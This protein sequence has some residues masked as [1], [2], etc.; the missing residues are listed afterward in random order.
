MG[1]KDNRITS[2]E[3]LKTEKIGLPALLSYNWVEGTQLIGNV[4]VPIQDVLWR[5][6]MLIT[7]MEN[8]LAAY[9]GPDSEYWAD[10]KIYK[11]LLSYEMSR[12]PQNHT[13]YLRAQAGW[14][15]LI[16]KEAQRLN[17]LLTPNKAGRV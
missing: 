3:E 14:I 13:K 2:F 10:A 7:D 1:Y 6:T 16:M 12:M 5:R 8:L 9:L 15:Q 11:D 17:M 4:G